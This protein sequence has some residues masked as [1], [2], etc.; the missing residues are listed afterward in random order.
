MN[1]RLYKKGNKRNLIIWTYTLKSTYNTKYQP[2]IK[3]SSENPYRDEKIEKIDNNCRL[4]VR[5]EILTIV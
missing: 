2:I 4:L 1:Y 5:Y 3:F